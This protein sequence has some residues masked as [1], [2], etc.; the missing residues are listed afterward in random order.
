[1]NV[2][3]QRPE[4][5]PLEFL[6][7][8]MR[9]EDPPLEFLH[10]EMRPEGPAVARPGRQA[11]IKGITRNRAPKARHEFSEISLTNFDRTQLDRY[12]RKISICISAHNLEHKKS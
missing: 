10:F 12:V 1:M 4:D 2:V 3:K 11:G 8:E 5:P 6:H 9:P 7:F